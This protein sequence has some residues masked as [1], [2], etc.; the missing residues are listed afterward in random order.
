MDTLEKTQLAV[1]TKMAALCSR[2]EQC[3]PDIRKKITDLGG[4]EVM[5]T[6]VLQK[7]KEE[8]FLDDERYSKAYVRDKFRFNKWGRIKIRYYLKLKGLPD[9]V[10]N[11][12]LEELDETHYIELLVKT[13]KEKA[14]T[15]KNKEKFEKMAALVRFAQSRGFEPELIHRHMGAVLD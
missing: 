6:E 7:L 3:S 10:I 5:V 12:G 2:A 9:Q 1:F 11:V 4:G 14:K 13:M 8:H 15:L